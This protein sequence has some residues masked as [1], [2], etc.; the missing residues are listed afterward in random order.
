MDKIQELFTCLGI[1]PEDTQHCGS[2]S[3][4]VN[5]LN[6]SHHHTHVPE[7]EFSV[8]CQK[9]MW[10][11]HCNYNYGSSFIYIKEYVNLYHTEKYNLNTHLHRCQLYFNYEVN[12]VAECQCDGWPVE[13]YVRCN[14]MHGYTLCKTS[15]A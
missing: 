2:Y 15:K 4:A 14:E 10:P 11:A 12:S 1:I 13:I 5:L 6:S 3:L 8:N 9:S 7:T